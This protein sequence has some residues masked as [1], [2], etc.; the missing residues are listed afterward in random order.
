MKLFQKTPL[1]IN[2]FNI[3]E[4][5]ILQLSQSMQISLSDYQIDHLAIR[6][7]HQESAEKWLN[8]LMKYGK[9]I[10]DNIVNGRVIYIIKLNMPL[11][12]ANQ[13]V[14]VIELPFPKGKIYP[15]EGWEHLEIVMPFLKNEMTSQWIERI[16][17]TFLWYKNS[18]LKLKISEP[19]VEG[20]KLPNPSIAVSF[21][22][23][24]ENHTC[25][26]IHPYTIEDV[27]AI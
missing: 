3:F 27:I 15:V 10:S 18:Q 9:I 17:N 20:E 12:F 14:S 5:K 26:K 4:Q 21:W 8:L 25:I 19:K 6:V 16:Q 13:K 11:N 2:E 7:N 24:S 22:D 1:L 23:S